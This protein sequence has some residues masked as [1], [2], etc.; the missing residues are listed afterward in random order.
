MPN[1]KKP[2]ERICGFTQFQQWP[3]FAATDNGPEGIGDIG[4]PPPLRPFPLASLD[5][6]CHQQQNKLWKCP[7]AV[8]AFSLFL[9]L[10]ELQYYFWVKTIA[11]TRAK[12]LKLGLFGFVQ[13]KRG[14]AEEDE[15]GKNAGME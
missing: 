3:S 10:T 15:E 12:L 1:S 5:L 6:D 11:E 8:G 4:P 7:C 14:N 9:S 13:R 2:L